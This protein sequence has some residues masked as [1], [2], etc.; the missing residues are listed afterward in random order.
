M[1]RV[2]LL[3]VMVFVCL[4]TMQCCSGREGETALVILEELEA[5][6]GV[7]DPEDRLERLDIFVKNHPE[8]YFRRLAYWESFKTIADDVGSLERASEY[9][10]GVLAKESDHALRGNLLLRKFAYV[11]KK[12]RRD[13]ASLAAEML[14]GGEV[15]PK[16]FLYM[17]YYLESDDEYV[18]LTERCLK[19]ALELVSDGFLRSRI[20]VVLGEFLEEQGRRDEALEVLRKA[21]MDAFSGGSLGEILWEEGEREIALDHYIRYIAGVPSG[22]ESVPLD[23]LFVLVNGDMS[24]LDEMIL[25]KRIIDEGPLEQHAFVDIE[26]RRH[27]LADYIGDN[28]VIII[29]SPT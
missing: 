1:T 22:V 13:A 11:F 12:N 28:L 27:D 8:D 25:S 14:D 15:S 26:G 20:L 23:S 2:S 24:G 29:W 4:M 21:G 17:A 7:K 18:E 9:L 16:L 19:R 3:I 10:D 6:S 5:A